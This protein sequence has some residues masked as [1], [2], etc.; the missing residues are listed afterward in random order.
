[1][2]L[3]VILS[4][5]CPASAW[6]ECE[7]RFGVRIIEFYGMSDAAGNLVNTD[8]KVGSVGKP[9][10]GAQYRIADENDRPLPPGSSGAIQFRHPLGQVTHYHNLP[11]ETAKAY[12]GGWFH[13]GD[14]GEM[15]ADGYFYFRGRLKEA[16]R[17]RGENISAWEI[18]TVVD[19][20][21]KVKESVAFGVPSELGEEEVMLAVVLKPDAKCSPEEILAFCQERLAYYAIPRF[22]EFVE[23]LP[24]TGTQKIQ[25]GILK[26]QGRSQ[27]TWDREKAGYVVKKPVTAN[28]NRRRAP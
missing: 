3:R 12:R 17:R 18:E 1:N 8:G 27:K 15:D 10:A 21:P 28:Q 9:I 2:P 7:D 24:K 16:I 22:I 11:D 26:D 4:V 14:T 19:F 13:S 20:H 5:G 25:R 23:A 6:R